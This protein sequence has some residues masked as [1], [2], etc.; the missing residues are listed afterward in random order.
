MTTEHKIEIYWLGRPTTIREKE[1]NQI[2]PL[3]V[4]ERND[5][6]SSPCGMEL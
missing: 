6:K 4:L 2:H 1:K 5:K 3:R